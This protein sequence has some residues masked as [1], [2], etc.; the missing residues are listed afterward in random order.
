MF[1]PRMDTNS[2]MVPAVSQ[3]LTALSNRMENRPGSIPFEQ[4][5]QHHGHLRLI[6]GH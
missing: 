1:R 5:F 4:D 6:I 3:Y 2:R